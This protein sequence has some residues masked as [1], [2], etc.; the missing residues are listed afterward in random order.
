MPTKKE[1][2]ERY[3]TTME[4]TATGIALM[5]LTWTMAL[6]IMITFSDRTG[7]STRIKMQAKV[8]ELLHAIPTLLHNINMS[9]DNWIKTKEKNQGEFKNGWMISEYPAEFISY[10]GIY[11]ITFNQLK[12]I[13]KPQGARM[14]DIKAHQIK[15]MPN[16]KDN[17]PYFMA[18]ISQKGEFPQHLKS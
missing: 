7:A 5:Q 13:C 12:K 2:I 1:E 10:K 9:K 3:R 17:T 4:K 14:C 15:Y 11:N 16:I 8:N 6:T 18:K